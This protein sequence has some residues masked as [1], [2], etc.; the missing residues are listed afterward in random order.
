MIVLKVAAVLSLA[1]AALA[2]DCGQDQPRKSGDPSG[3]QIAKAIGAQAIIDGIC[4][5]NW[6]VGDEKKLENT[7]NHGSAYEIEVSNIRRC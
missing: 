7:F 4:V 1:S 6:R 3:A 2:A 5:G